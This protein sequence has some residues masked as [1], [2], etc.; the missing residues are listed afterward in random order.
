MRCEYCYVSDPTKKEDH[1]EGCIGI[2]LEDTKARLTYA[3]PDMYAALKTME[4]V[5]AAN[6]E[7]FLKGKVANE[8]RSAIRKAEGMSQPREEGKAK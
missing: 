4:G 2:L 6:G 1:Y 7:G 5:F 3:A 8:I